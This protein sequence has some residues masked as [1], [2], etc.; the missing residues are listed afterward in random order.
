MYSSENTIGLQVIA[1]DE[2]S[3]ATHMHLMGVLSNLRWVDFPGRSEEA[4]VVHEQIY[5]MPHNGCVEATSTQGPPVLSDHHWTLHCA[6]S[7]TV[8]HLC[9]KATCPM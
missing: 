6:N 2:L 1:E 7:T 8:K 5:D 4:L 3:D 9:I